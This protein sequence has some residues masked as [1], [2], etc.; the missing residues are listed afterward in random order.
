MPA[1]VQ[2]PSRLLGAALALI[3]LAVIVWPG[4]AVV[5]T[6]VHGA[7]SQAV[8]GPVNPQSGGSTV[9]T[10]PPLSLA[11]SIGLLIQTLAWGIGIGLVATIYAW[12]AAWL[13][14]QR[15]WGI[16]GLLCVPLMLPTY[17]CYTAY[18]ILRSPG[19]FLDNWLE[20]LAKS[21]WTEAPTIAGRMIAGF[22]LTLWAWPIAAIILGATVRRLDQSV[23]DALALEAKPARRNAEVV[24]LCRVGILGAIGA[25]S[26]VMIGSAVPL[27][28]SQV[29][30]YST[31]IW[32]DLT[33]APGSWRVWAAAW[34]LLVIAFVAGWVVATRLLRSAATHDEPEAA[35]APAHAD[36]AGPLTGL[37][38]SA[39]TIVPLV[40]FAISLSIVTR[41]NETT[42]TSYLEPALSQWRSVP[43]FF[44]LTGESLAGSLVVSI[45]VAVVSLVIAAA[46]WQSLSARPRAKGLVLLST[47][48]LVIAGIFPGVLIGSAFSIASNM[49]EATRD[50]ADTPWIMVLG[51]TARFGFVPA[52]VGCWLAAIEPR[53]E[54]DLRA[55]DGALNLR[56]WLGA[57]LPVQAGALIAAALAAGA[58]SMHEIESAI[59]IQPPGSPSLAQV[60]LNDLHQLR[61][62]DLS[63]A[64]VILVGGGL[65]A[66]GVAALGVWW[67]ARA[68]L[69]QPSKFPATN[70]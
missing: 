44:K 27:H 22:G 50:F 51:H 53:Q 35:P 41:Q 3:V 60:L 58:L 4:A 26:L 61:M 62:Q 65:I 57:S 67:T 25:I 11:P 54:R 13:I 28:L 52:L 7:T 1:P 42:H 6:V 19:W 70:T 15:G 16:I 14:R 56:G 30:T 55:L 40:L 17:L 23:L 29:P 21:G 18:G 63:A 47:R 12:P 59:V 49:T 43:R 46:T 24:W 48:A 10:L 36:S 9:E 39:S 66:A 31:K 45:G 38:W 33:L 34:P 37:I 20:A 8:S 69:S 68:R 2:R 5:W 64:G 32:L